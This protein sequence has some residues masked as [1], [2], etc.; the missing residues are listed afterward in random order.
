MGEAYARPGGEGAE[1]SLERLHGSEGDKKDSEKQSPGRLWEQMRE[2][3]WSPCEES[4]F[5]LR[6]QGNGCS[7]YSKGSSDEVR[8]AIQ[9]VHSGSCAE[10]GG[11]GS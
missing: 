4:A 8:S 6:L 11:G 3:L 7:A 5:I 2:G 1:G 10:L 9:N